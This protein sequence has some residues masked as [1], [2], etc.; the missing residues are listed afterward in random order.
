MYQTGGEYI[1][2]EEGHFSRQVIISRPDVDLLQTGGAHAVFK[3][4]FVPFV[5]P[6]S[7]NILEGRETGKPDEHEYNLKSCCYIVYL[8]LGPSLLRLALAWA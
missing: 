3:L 7:K 5:S 4:H 6:K 2:L 1:I 8:Y